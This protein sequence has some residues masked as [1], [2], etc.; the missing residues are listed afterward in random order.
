MTDAQQVDDGGPVGPEVVAG[1]EHR[2]EGRRVVDDLLGGVDV[3]V[4]AAERRGHG[5]AA[6]GV[7]VEQQGPHPVALGGPGGGV[8]EGHDL[9]GDDGPVERVLEGERLGGPGEVALGHDRVV[10]QAA[11]G[12]VGGGALVGGQEHLPVGLARRGGPAARASP[13]GS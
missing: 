2:V 7:E 12:E 4:E 5:H 8:R 1:A 3:A 10:A 6:A 11:G 13:P 9:A